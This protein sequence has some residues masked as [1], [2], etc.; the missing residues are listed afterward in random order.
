M[1][2]GILMDP[3][4]HI[5]PEKD[6]SFALLLEAQ[7]RHHDV[8]YM[9][10]QDIWLQDGICWGRMQSL[11][12]TDTPDNWFTFHDERVQP[13]ADLDIMLMRK[14]PPFDMQYIYLTYLLEQ[15][16]A[17]GLCVVNKPSSL[18]DANEKLFTAWFPQCC[19]N[20]FV[21]NRIDLLRDFVLSEKK[22]V[23]K[24]LGAMGGESIFVLHSEDVNLHV[25]LETMT[26]HGAHF[27]MAQ[28]YIPEVTQGDKRILMV[29]GQPIPYGLSRIPAPDDFRGNLASGARSQPTELT[30]HD[31]WI[32]EQV[33]PTLL[34][35]GLH[36]VGLDVIGNYLTEINV[37]SPTC[38]REIET[39]YDI[40]IAAEFFNGIEP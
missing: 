25:I 10:A 19:P 5:R 7:T 24:P 4:Q 20:T 16:E 9:E 2:L 39:A 40:N 31:L 17:Q 18:R 26:Q 33:G 1:K 8:Y 28:R 14:D 11:S 29:N 15:A 34:K 32:A 13:L 37:T 36:F 12:V 30:D 3:I 23:V 21:S 27:I 6:T 35:K 22:V 38:A